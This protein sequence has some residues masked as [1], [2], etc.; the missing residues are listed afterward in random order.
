MRN[1][2]I[3]IAG[4][5]TY[6]DQTKL[7]IALPGASFVD[8]SDI[9]NDART[10]KSDEEIALIDRANLVFDAAVQ[11]IHEKARPGMLG[12]EQL[13]LFMLLLLAARV[14]CRGPWR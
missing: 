14:H 8:V 2:T 7:M 1:G 9:L 11:R 12:G 13:S 6:R 3:G 4:P 10:I 5:F